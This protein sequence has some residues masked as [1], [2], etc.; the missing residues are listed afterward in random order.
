MRI[1]LNWL[2]RYVQFKVTSE[3]LAQR[4]TSVG[5]EVESIEQLGAAFDKFV[6]GE[7]LSVR[8]HPNADKLSLCEVRVDASKEFFRVSP[9][10]AN[11]V[12]CS[13]CS[14]PDKKSQ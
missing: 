12:W 9:R 1:S 6:V 11:S 13:E 4:L 14:C 5:L 7:V 2:G 10:S 3:E 8:K